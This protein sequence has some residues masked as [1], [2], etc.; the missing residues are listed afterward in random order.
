[1]TDAFKGQRMDYLYR[2]TETVNIQDWYLPYRERRNLR[3]HTCSRISRIRHGDE[4]IL[5]NIEQLNVH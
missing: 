3:K 5:R 1:M 4:C 2:T